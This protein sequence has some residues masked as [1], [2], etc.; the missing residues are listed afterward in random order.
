MGV[1]GKED[2]KNQCFKKQRNKMGPKGWN[3]VECSH[4]AVHIP[5]AGSVLGI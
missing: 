2:S 5:A 1:E 3:N 4:L